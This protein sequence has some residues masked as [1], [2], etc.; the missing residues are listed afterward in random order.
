MMK[1]L[2]K[3]FCLLILVLAIIECHFL[4]FQDNR[5]KK[6]INKHKKRKNRKLKKSFSK[7]RIIDGDD[8]SYKNTLTSEMEKKELRF[9]LLKSLK[10]KSD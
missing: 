10:N 8:R 9:N 4:L 5:I 2:L 6:N 1:N 3:Q 7:S